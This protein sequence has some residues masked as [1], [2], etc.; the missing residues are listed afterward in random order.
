MKN[1]YKRL[2]AKILVLAVSLFV[3]SLLYSKSIKGEVVSIQDGDTI[4]VLKAKKQY[5]IRLDGID[6]PEKN[7]AF[8]NVAR[9]FTSDLVFRK[10]VKVKYEKRDRY[11]RY[12]GTVITPGGKNLNH[13]LLKAGLA[14]QYKY[15][16][17]PILK[18]LET[19][20]RRQRK[21]LWSD[22]KPIAPWDFRRG[23]REKP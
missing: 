5:R 8:G 22:A 20:A 4:T 10:T 17:S 14:W 1:D 3:G 2:L 9:K 13:E 18:S 19:K 6:C 23:V 11:G 16:K 7:Q 12:L 21:G 15:N